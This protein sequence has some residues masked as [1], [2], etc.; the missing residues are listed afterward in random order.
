[1]ALLPSTSADHGMQERRILGRLL[2]LYEEQ[3]G[4][5]QQVLHLSRRQGDTVRA[6]G[7]L[8]EVRRILGEKKRCLDLVARL[9]MTER[10]AK[11]DWEKGRRLWSSAGKA[12]LHGTLAE[13]TD[14]IEEILACEEKNDM[15][16]IAMTQVV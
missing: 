16:L 15:E 3:R 1:M 6:G 14:L 9:E 4:V 8:A 12:R 2:G 13:I 10:D 11:R 7:S 5:Y